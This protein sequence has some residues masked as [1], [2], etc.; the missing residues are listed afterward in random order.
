MTDV[1]LTPKEAAT[2]LGVK[3]GTLAN[4]RVEGKPSLPFVKVGRLV[5]YKRSDLDRH[6]RSNTKTHT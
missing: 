1:L 5:K 4:W 2:Y 6:I 3:P